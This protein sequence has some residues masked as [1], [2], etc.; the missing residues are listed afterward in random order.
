MLDRCAGHDQRVEVTVPHLLPGAIERRQV[1]L[2]GVPRFIGRRPQQ[3]HLD[4]Q[5]CWCQSTRRSW[6]SV[7]I[8]SGIRLSRAIQ[9]LMSW[10]SAMSSVM[11][12]MRSFS[13]TSRAGRSLGIF[14]GMAV[15]P[16]PLARTIGPVPRSVRHTSRSRALTERTACPEP[17]TNKGRRH[18]MRNA[19]LDIHP[20]AGRPAP[21]SAAW[22]WPTTSATR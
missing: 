17:D 2:R 21:R 16:P 14:I 15:S 4:L 20:I 19:S 1:L 11:T 6:V 5:R 8:F 10:R 12:G 22:T 18:K 13:S 9:S 7:L 3:R